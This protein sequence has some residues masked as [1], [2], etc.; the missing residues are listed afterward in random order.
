MYEYIFIL[1][2]AVVRRITL[3]I[4]LISSKEI[5]TIVCDATYSVLRTFRNWFQMY[6]DL[7]LLSLHRTYSAD[8]DVCSQMC[9]DLRPTCSV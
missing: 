1:F 4:Y 6:R 2:I 3:K 8:E 9:S 7:Q 5:L